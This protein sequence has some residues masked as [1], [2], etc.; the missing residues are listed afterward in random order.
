MIDEYLSAGFADVDDAKNQDAYFACLALLDSLPYFCEYK[1]KSYELLQLKP[2]MKVLEAGCGLGDDAF[3]IA[4]RIM[5]GGTVVALDSSSEMIEKAKSRELS[6]HL[7]VQFQTGDVRA[8]PFADNSFT[9]CRIDR[10][11]QHIPQP[12]RAISEL[13]RVLEQG[14]V[15]LAY[16]N[17]W[18]TFSITARD[19]EMTRCLE[20][21]WCDSLTN[22]LIGR[23]LCDL[24]ISSGLSDIRMQPS[25]CI[26][27]DFEMADKVYNLRETARRATLEGVISLEQGYH[28]IEELIS[29]D[30]KGSFIAALTAYTVVG[31]K[32]VDKN[33]AKL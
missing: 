1:L 21:C 19:H 25:T 24:F 11:L 20:N 29:R 15:L 32:N 8:L 13:V 17:D 28:W 4:E 26:I 18:G 31:Q 6:K 9:R 16:D 23:N 5:P 22:S 30:K 2:G 7:S 10:V 33:E 14:G 3:R 12:E 27:N